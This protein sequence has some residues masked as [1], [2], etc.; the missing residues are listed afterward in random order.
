MSS[1]NKLFA[2]A[3]ALLGI[4][5]AAL[6]FWAWRHSGLTLLQLDIGLC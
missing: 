6:A 4:V 1:K 5:A 2:Y 3:L